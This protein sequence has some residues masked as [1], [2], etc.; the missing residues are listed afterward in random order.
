MGW[1]KYGLNIHF[2][3][4]VERLRHPSATLTNVGLFANEND[5]LKIEHMPC[6]KAQVKLKRLTCTR[7][8]EKSTRPKWSSRPN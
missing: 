6:M 2:L 5:L 1:S 3:Y 8:L 4:S 7:F